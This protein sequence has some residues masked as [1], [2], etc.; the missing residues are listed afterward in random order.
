MDVRPESGDQAEGGAWGE[1]PLVGSYQPVDRKARLQ[2]L[3]LEPLVQEIAD[4]HRR[5][6][7]HLLHRSLAETSQ[8]ERAAEQRHALPP[9]RRRE[10]RRRHGEDRVQRLGELAQELDEP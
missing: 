9:T 4:R 2:Q 7:E 3:R 1:W 8:P 10:T 6:A 5:D